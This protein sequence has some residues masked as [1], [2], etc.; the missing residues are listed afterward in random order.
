MYVCIWQNILYF[1]GWH[2]IIDAQ[3]NQQ[4]QLFI[5]IKYKPYED[6]HGETELPCPDTYFP[7]RKVPSR[8]Y[9]MTF[10]GKRGS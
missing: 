2:D 5:K 10:K 1:T 9:V 8:Y 4:G 3:N 6:N 7:L